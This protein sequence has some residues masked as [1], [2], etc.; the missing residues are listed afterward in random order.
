M[1]KVP[2]VQ[3]SH[4]QLLNIYLL[5]KQI[6]Q[7]PSYQLFSTYSEG[8]FFLEVFLEVFL[9][10][11]L[12]VFPFFLSFYPSSCLSISLTQIN[13]ES[14]KSRAS[15]HGYLSSTSPKSLHSLHS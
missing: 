14:K 2:R 9:G 4:G 7:L 13:I 10:G 6:R 8:F 1:R 11:F 3:A 15:F 12:G 5:E